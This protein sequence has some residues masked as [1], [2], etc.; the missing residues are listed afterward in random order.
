MLE[1]LAPVGCAMTTPCTCVVPHKKLLKALFIYSKL[2]LRML[3]AEELFNI[4]PLKL[5]WFICEGN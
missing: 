4:I 2:S 3:E 1:E 5:P